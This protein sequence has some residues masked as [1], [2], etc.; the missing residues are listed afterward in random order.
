ML[1]PVLWN[2]M[3]R[4]QLP[5]IKAYAED[6]TISLSYC[7]QESYCAVADINRQLKEAEEWGKVW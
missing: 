7:R 1:G 6:C 2:I 5:A 4:R 3:Q